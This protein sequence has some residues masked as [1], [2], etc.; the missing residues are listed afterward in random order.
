MKGDSLTAR[1]GL[2]TTIIDDALNDVVMPVVNAL[3][4]ALSPVITEII[5]ELLKV[6]DVLLGA[7]TSDLSILFVDIPD[8]LVEI[9]NLFD[10][11]GLRALVKKAFKEVIQNYVTLLIPVVN[12]VTF[13]VG[14]VITLIGNHCRG[15]TGIIGSK[16]DDV[17]RKVKA[18]IR[19]V[20]SM[21]IGGKGNA[22]EGEFSSAR[23][24]L[25]GY[26]ENLVSE[27]ITNA[28]NIRYEAS[29]A[30]PQPEL[31]VSVSLEESHKAID[32][33]V[34]A[35]KVES[36]QLRDN[37]VNGM[38]SDLRVME[39][40]A[41]RHIRASRELEYEVTRRMNVDWNNGMAEK[42]ALLARDT[43][44]VTGTI[45]YI[46]KAISI[47]LIIIVII[48]VLLIFFAIIRYS[49]SVGSGKPKPHTG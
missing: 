33:H 15:L 48:C 16:Y 25:I 19:S 29:I 32:T 31:V 6:L 18:I 9:M 11:V 46:K 2:V 8:P 20:N 30:I 28:R 49:I 27:A 22:V 24:S 10:F 45:D 7:L 42:N 38:R 4:G 1:D 35:L 26:V 41:T 44:K 14:D 21:S 47:I 17:S 5:Q 12:L 3:I 36:N 37:F 39:E 34:T 13:E 23:Q 43:Q 40:N